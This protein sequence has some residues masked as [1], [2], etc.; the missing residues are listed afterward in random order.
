MC[1]HKCVMHFLGNNFLNNHSYVY[2]ISPNFYQLLNCMYLCR[3][4]NSVD[5]DQIG[6][7]LIWI[8]SVLKKKDKSRLSVKVVNTHQLLCTVDYGAQWLSD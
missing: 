6:S 8:C 4:E 2:Y 5:P 1:M 7:L 3:D